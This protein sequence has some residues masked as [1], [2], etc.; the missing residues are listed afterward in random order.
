MKICVRVF[1][2]PAKARPTKDFIQQKHD[3]SPKT[4]PKNTTWSQIDLHPLIRTHKSQPQKSCLCHP[5]TSLTLSE[6]KGT[7]SKFI[8]QPLL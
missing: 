6:S 8:S 5:A 7:T 1:T 4:R 3:L 2:S